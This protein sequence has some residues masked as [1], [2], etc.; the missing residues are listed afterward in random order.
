M[1]DRFE[2]GFQCPQCKQWF[3][4]DKS[5]DAVCRLCA[6]DGQFLPVTLK[7]IPVPWWFVF[8]PWKQVGGRGY[9]C[10]GVAP[11]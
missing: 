3:F 10:V 8:C 6:Y 9:H 7:F 4:A 1:T 5:K 11:K 2:R